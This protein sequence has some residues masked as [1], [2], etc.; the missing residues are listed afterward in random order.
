MQS[1]HYKFISKTSEHKFN[2]D[3]LKI[4]LLLN[5]YFC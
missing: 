4:I 3:T 2:F 5:K 1:K